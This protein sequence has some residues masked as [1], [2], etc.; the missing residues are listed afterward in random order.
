MNNAENSPSVNLFTTFFGGDA[1]GIEAQQK[2]NDLVPA[3]IYIY[4]ATTKK[5]SY[6]NKRLSDMLGY[7]HSEINS[8]DTLVFKDDVAAVTKELEK[9]YTLKENETHTY[10]S[11]LNHKKGDWRYFRTTGSV[12]KR[13]EKGEAAALLFIAEDI[14]GTLETEDEVQVKKTLIKETEELLQFGTW[15]WETATNK[16]EWSEGIFKLLGCN[17]GEVDINLEG[18]LNFISQADI[19]I[20]TEKVKVAAET[21]TAFEHTYNLTDKEGHQKIVTT[22]GKVLL[23]AEG[24]P[25]K[26]IGTTRDVTSQINAYRELL[27]YKQMTMEKE[28]FLESGSWEVDLASGKFYWS[29]GM[30]KLFEYDISNSDNVPSLDAD[31]YFSHFSESD[32]DQIKK[33][34]NEML[35]HGD[36]YAREEIIT[37]NNGERKRLETYGKVIRNSD[38]T[39]VKVMGATKNVSRLKEYERQLEKKLVE[40]E[41]SNKELEEFAYVASHDLQEPLRKISTFSERLKV[42]FENQLG[43]DGNGYIKRML[44]AAANMRMLIENL[45]NF[46]RLTSKKVEY[47]QASLDVL[48]E[49]TLTEI[50]LQIDES[51]ALIT[52]QNMPVLEVIPSQ[53]KQL[54]SNIIL[55]A[56]KFSK[57]AATPVINIM[58]R[59]VTAEQKEVHG[60]QKDMPYYA[61]SIKDNGIGFEQEYAEKIFQIFQRLHGKSEYPGA[62]IGLAIC[63]KIVENHHGRLFA[64]G[65][66]DEGA[67]FTIILP[68]RNN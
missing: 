37:A 35:S 22:T 51:Q 47:I 15:T 25:T 38:G 19:N 18:Y 14:T 13:N 56:V 6:A 61:I 39:P 17:P 49:E 24:Q 66:P 46:S 29:D 9:L 55:N 11:R 43:E 30:F 31:F 3:I 7:Q 60:L 5:L 42:K 54:F 58:C 64:D 26:I 20:L 40:L 44:S 53:I 23:S 34:W 1:A 50:E 12:L 10:K 52:K 45:L 32:I 67:T 8:W 59:I 21:N 27:H 63:K 2:I 33:D 48:L 65:K 36:N 68:E 41:R 28:I 4:D 62:G 57:P 16:M